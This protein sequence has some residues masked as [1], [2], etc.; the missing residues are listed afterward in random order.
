MC[1]QCGALWQRV[2]L[3]K[4][5]VFTK[6]SMTTVI[7]VIIMDTFAVAI[8]AFVCVCA[9]FAGDRSSDYGASR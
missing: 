1:E 5:F 4:V 3:W 6:V 8:L 9:R 2:G 7:C